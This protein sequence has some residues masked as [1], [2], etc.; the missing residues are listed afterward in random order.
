M[1]TAAAEGGL[2]APCDGSIK[3]DDDAPYLDGD[4]HHAILAHEAAALVN[5]HAQAIGV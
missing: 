5:L 1:R 3:D 4:M 2:E